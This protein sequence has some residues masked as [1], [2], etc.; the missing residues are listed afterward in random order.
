MGTIA[1]TVGIVFL[2]LALLRGY[3]TIDAIVFMIGIIVANVPEGLLPQMTVALTITAQRMRDKEVVVSNLEI[4]ESL[5]AVNVICSDKTGTLTCNRMT[6]VHL[7]C[8]GEIFTT[9][10]TQNMDSD[11]FRTFDTSDPAFVELLMGVY[12]NTDCI[13][14]DDNPDILKR[15]TKGDASEAALIKFAEEIK[16]IKEVRDMYKRHFIVPFNSTNKWMCSITSRILEGENYEQEVTMYLKG[17]PEK[18]MDRCTSYIYNGKVYPMDENARKQFEIINNTLARRGERVLGFATCKL[19]KDEQGQPFT[20]DYPYSID[21][22]PNFNTENLTFVGFFAL[23]DPP[24]PGVKKAIEECHTAGIKVFMVTGDHPTTAHAIA[25]SLNLITGDTLEELNEKGTTLTDGERAKAIVIKGTDLLDYNDEMWDF[26]LSHEEIVFARTMPQQKQDIVNHLRK[27][28]FIIAMTGD[29]VNDAPA[30]KAAHVGI[31]MGSGA[32][33]AKEAGQIILMNDDFSSIVDGIREGRLIFENLKKCICYVL[34]S[35]I[36]ELIP[37]LLFIIIKIPLSIETIMIILIDVGTDIAPAITLAYEE[38]EDMIMQVPPR[39]RD[40]HL[41]GF[42]L[43]VWAYLVY[44][45]CQTFISY[46]AFIWVYYD[47]GFTLYDLLGAGIGYR[48]TW[49]VNVKNP[50]RAT[51]F[52]NMCMNNKYYQ[53]NMVSVGKNCQQDFKDHI[54]YILM[55][56]QSSFLMT[57]VFTQMACNFIRKTQVATIFNVFRLTSNKAI[58]VGLLIEIAVIVLVIYT[59]GLN[60]ALLLTYVPPKYASTALWGIPFFILFDELRKLICRIEPKY[61]SLGGK[62]GTGCLTYCSTF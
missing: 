25:K 46:F 3:S 15:T 52:I 50:E 24:R 31:A 55:V 17:A 59:P 5:G 36:P 39:A 42:K 11:S 48:D 27:L 22:E 30:L 8:N 40:A 57:I 54:I 12:L 4:I 51:F 26:A 19:I 29:G 34:T 56:A 35:N 13:F 61:L 62:E 6:V 21:P 23:I 33:V 43:M 60:N 58:Y 16:S 44:G 2:I 49:E 45:M 1:I 38:P 18:V 28:D 47:F 7:V 37:F 20:P 10:H 41:V 32:A 14:T 9:P 53:D